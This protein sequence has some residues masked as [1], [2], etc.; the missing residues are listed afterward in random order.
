MELVWTTLPQATPSAEF[1]KLVGGHPLVAQLLVQR[2]IRTPEAARSFLHT[3][4]Y[5]PAPPTNLIGVELAAQ[6]LY[7]AI[8]TDQ[9][10]LVW[11]D[12]DV[13]GQTSTSLLVSGLQA[14]TKPGRVR[15]HVPNRFTESHGIR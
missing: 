7:E 3:E 5:T 1:A 6:L 14:L 15:F 4:H 12:F 11:G 8:R 9:N 13:D 10:I 2:G